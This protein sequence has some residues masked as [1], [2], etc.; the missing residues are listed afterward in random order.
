MENIYTH[1]WKWL[2]FPNNNISNL[3]KE[4]HVYF[5]K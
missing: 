3:N 5:I 4:E 2:T 1:V